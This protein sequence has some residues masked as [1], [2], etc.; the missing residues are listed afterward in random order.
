MCASCSAGG[1]SGGPVGS[2]GEDSGDKFWGR[3]K[4]E[5]RRSGIWKKEGE[6]EW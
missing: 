2:R 3:W 1:G 6:W 5:V 4:W